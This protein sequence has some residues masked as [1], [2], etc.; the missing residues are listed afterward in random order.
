MQIVKMGLL[1]NLCDFIYGLTPSALCIV[2][3]GAI[4][5]MRYKFIRV[6]LDSHK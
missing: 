1:I 2:T 4:K 5:F 3:Y 6:A